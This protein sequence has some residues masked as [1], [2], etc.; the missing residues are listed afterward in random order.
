MSTKWSTRSRWETGYSADSVEWCPVEP[1]RNVLVCGTYQ[2][3]KK[4]DQGTLY[5]ERQEGLRWN[6]PVM[7]EH[8]KKSASERDGDED[9]DANCVSS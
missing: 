9:S 4:D 8:P 7:N 6:A 3:D 1:F 5:A 2:L